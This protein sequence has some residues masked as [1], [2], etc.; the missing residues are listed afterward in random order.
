MQFARW[1]S[2]VGKALL[3]LYRFVF[4]S[5]FLLL[6]GYQAYASH[7][8]AGNITYKNIGQN[9]Y[10]VTLT[11]FTNPCSRGVDRCQVTIEVWG[12][13]NGKYYQVDAPELV[14]INR[15][16]GTKPLSPFLDACAG[17]NI[18]PGEII[19]NYPGGCIK[20]N[21]YQG[22]ITLRGS[23]CFVFRYYDFARVEGV[24]NM[25]NSGNVSWYCETTLCNNT[26][27]GG[28]DSPVIKNDPVD[29]ACVGKEWSYNPAAYDPNGDSLVFSLR[30]SQN[31]DNSSIKIPICSPGYVFPDQIFPS[32]NNKFSV[33][34]R[35]GVVTWKSPQLAGIYN[36]ALV[37]DSYRGGGYTGTIVRDIAI[38]VDQCTNNPPILSVGKDTCVSTNQNIQFTARARDPDAGD[39]LYFYNTNGSDG[40]SAPFLL[41][42]TLIPPNDIAKQPQL[43]ALQPPNPNPT[44]PN[45]WPISTVFGWTPGCNALSHSPW[46]VDFY[47]HD[48]LNRAVPSP[49]IVTGP[50]LA[51]NAVV[52]INVVAQGVGNVKA[53]R[54]PNR[55]VRL[56][57]T[58]AGVCTGI[59]GFEVYRAIDSLN[60][61][62]NACCT[63]NPTSGG[64]QKIATL[65]DTARSYT[66]GPNLP[67]RGKYCYRIVSV[68]QPRGTGSELVRSCPSNQSCVSL[69]LQA[70]II[71]NVDVTQTNATTGS[72]FVLWR[73]PNFSL[74]NTTFY[75]PPYTYRLEIS[76]GVGSSA[77]TPV[78]GATALTDSF[79][80]VTGLN[81]AARGYTFRVKIVDKNNVVADSSSPAS[82][83]FLVASPLNKAAQVKWN[84]QN[85]WINDSYD[86]Y[87][88]STITG[89]Y[90]L[91]ATIPVTDI[92]QTSFS[93]I[94]GGLL[95]GQQVCYYVQA[96]GSYRNPAIHTNTLINKSNRSCTA[97][98]DT[99]PPCLPSAFNSTIDCA[100]YSVT[101]AWNP[102]PDTC[103]GGI[104]FYNIWRAG[105][106]VLYKLE[107]HWASLILGDLT[108]VSLTMPQL[109]LPKQLLISHQVH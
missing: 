21:V 50:P 12:Y 55:S 68:Y 91:L 79:Y 27:V 90:T 39:S 11:T 64:Y 14:N 41:G 5:L 13:L 32:A 78:A 9:R 26:F 87:R 109:F 28:D 67:F 51:T 89:G 95:R 92:N 99:I 34:S 36:F 56:D 73:Q 101:F 76:S 75:P 16:N 105:I 22:I 8:L 45:F 20:K 70:P 58:T 97:A 18:P 108:V 48:N 103:G 107:M 63:D 77:F 15:I 88:A 33:N 84:I 37:I 3:P 65:K 29:R 62:P 19:R 52:N 61:A 4:L 59:I 24:L 23:G 40:P 44:D 46:R 10:L 82:S 35:T 47:A 17:S 60:V 104:A 6:S 30:C 38:Q 69:S 49:S 96:S 85:G 81:T 71:L 83:I 7:G 93:Y 43:V 31:Y 72:I 80:T 100:N 74:I 86:L 53:K 98:T 1:I 66:D 57:W 102:P 54:I 2:S 94:D 25:L 106:R 42:A